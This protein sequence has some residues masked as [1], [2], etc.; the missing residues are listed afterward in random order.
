[1]RTPSREG[2]D[3]LL[4]PDYSETRQQGPLL[5]VEGASC[6]QGSTFELVGFDFMVDA[7]LRPFVLEVN[8][9]P[10][11]AKQVTSGSPPM[12]GSGVLESPSLHESHEMRVR[13]C[14][15]SAVQTGSCDSISAAH[16]RATSLWVTALSG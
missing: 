11:L 12:P 8:L 9:V 13:V 5:Q 2:Q 14:V 1:L 3:D 15:T 6:W 10:S 16:G 4:D 7:D